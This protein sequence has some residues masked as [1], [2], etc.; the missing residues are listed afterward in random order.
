MAVEI[1]EDGFEVE[2]GNEYEDNFDESAEYNVN[3][4]VFSHQ[5]FFFFF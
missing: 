5:S 4:K 2:V 3:I 1:D